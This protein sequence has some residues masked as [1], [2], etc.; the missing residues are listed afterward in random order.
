MKRALLI[1]F[2]AWALALGPSLGALAMPVA[3]P[4][5]LG[6][7]DAAVIQVKGG[8]GHGGGHGWGHRGGRGHHYGWSRGRHRGWRW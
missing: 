6:L 4:D 3:S 2:A 1:G 5:A 7:P 8:H